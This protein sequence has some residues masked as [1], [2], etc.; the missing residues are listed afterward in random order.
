MNSRK[1]ADRIGNIDERL[2]QQAQNLPNYGVR[3]RNK[4]IKRI[5]TCAATLVL[6]VCSFAAGMAVSA[7]E[8]AVEPGQDSAQET[9]F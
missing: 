8:P 5:A 6:M 4:V 9:D 1:L 2:V 7:K 3:R